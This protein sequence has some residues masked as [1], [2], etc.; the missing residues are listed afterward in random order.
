MSVPHIANHY[1]HASI[2]GALRQ[3]FNL[4]EIFKETDIPCDLLEKPDQRLTD[5]QLSSVI[6]AM[7]RLLKDEWLGLAVT[8]AKNGCFALMMELCATKSTLGA[9]IDQSARFYSTIS[10]VMSIGFDDGLRHGEHHFFELHVRDSRY[11][12]DHLLQ[13]YLLLM[14]Q[15]LACWVINQRIPF[16]SIQFNYA[17]PAHI[18]EYPYLYPGE[19]FFNRERCGFYIPARFLGMPIVRQESDFQWFL[20]TSPA[21]ILHRLKDER[22]M[23]ETITSLLKQHKSM[24]T[25]TFEQVCESLCLTPRTACRKL[26]AEGTSFTQIKDTLLASRAVKLL[27]NPNLSVSDVGTGLGF[28]EACSFSRAFKRWTGEYPTQWRQQHLVEC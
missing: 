9:F 13:E 22:S 2:R 17:P 18:A 14:W 5:L 27:S 3:G 19:Q 4:A 1:L 11:D 25:L 21:P 16:A 8:P 15:R 20:D 24:A 23:S 6:K 26:K 7:W 12:E 10:D 28:S